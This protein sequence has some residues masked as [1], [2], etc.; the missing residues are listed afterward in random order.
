MQDGNGAARYD[1][2]RSPYWIVSRRRLGY[3]EALTVEFDGIEA[4]PIF[5]F[6]EEASLWS[7]PI[8]PDS[9]ESQLPALDAYFASNSTGGRYPRLECSRFLL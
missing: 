6:E 8:A 3:I 1:A 5:S 9:T 2:A 4:L 7:E